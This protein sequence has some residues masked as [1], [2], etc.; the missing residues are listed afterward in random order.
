MSVGDSGMSLTVNSDTASLTS[1]LP[2]CAVPVSSESRAYNHVDSNNNYWMC[3]I[4]NLDGAIE[5]S[6]CVADLGTLAWEKWTPSGTGFTAFLC[7]P[8]GPL[9]VEGI[10]GEGQSTTYD[11]LYSGTTYSKGSFTNMK[12]N[13]KTIALRNSSIIVRDD[14]LSSGTVDAFK[15][16]VLGQKIVYKLANHYTDFV[17]VVDKAALDGLAR[18]V[19]ST[20]ISNNA[21]ADMV[22]NYIKN[23]AAGSIV[24]NLPEQFKIKGFTY[25]GT[26]VMTNTIEFPETPFIVISVFGSHNNSGMWDVQLRPFVWGVK[27]VYAEWA[28]SVTSGVAHRPPTYGDN[29]ITI[30]ASGSDPG[31]VLNA[32][33]SL[34]TVLYI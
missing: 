15:A 24:K 4:Y 9:G 10:S 32:S 29:S 21:N 17:S 23:S 6:V 19:L 13:D 5:R 2:I 34:Y 14:S 12:Q 8:A 31:V 1:R 26:G 25:T 11:F 27:N 20:S 3:D 33:G 22:A 7:K 16:A 28:S 18:N 30:S